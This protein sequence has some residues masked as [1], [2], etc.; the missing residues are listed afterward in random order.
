MANEYEE[1]MKRAQGLQE[2]VQ[3]AQD[4][5]GRMTLR[6]VASNGQA[7]VDMDG[8][9]NLLDLTIAPE[10]LSE[11]VGVLRAVIKSAFDDA[12]GKTDMAI[13]RVMSVA[14][15]GMPV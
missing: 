12:K 3:A 14:T 7:I 11:G 6:G 13:D 2:R 9:Y 1:L 10:L 4:E 15:E 5:L 8:K